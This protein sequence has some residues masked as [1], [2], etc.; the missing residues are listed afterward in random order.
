MDKRGR[1]AFDSPQPLGRPR[2]IVDRQAS[3]NALL[4]CMFLI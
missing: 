1:I 4:S 2:S 3:T